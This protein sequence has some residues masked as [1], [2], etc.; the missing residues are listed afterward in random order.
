MICLACWNHSN[1]AQLD[2]VSVQSSHIRDLIN[3]SDL[4]HHL[5]RFLQPLAGPCIVHLFWSVSVSSTTGICLTEIYTV[6]QVKMSSKMFTSGSVSDVSFIYAIFRDLR[7]WLGSMFWSQIQSCQRL[8]W[9][10][11]CFR[12]QHLLLTLDFR[13]F[14]WYCSAISI[15]Q[16]KHINDQS[17][18]RH[19][20]FILKVVNNARRSAGCLLILP[21]QL[22]L[23]TLRS[24]TQPSLE[25]SAVGC[26]LNWNI[27][28][29]IV[30][31][32][33]DINF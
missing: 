22:L 8:P 5:A 15:Q 13:N 33:E 28:F 17:L 4:Q 2:L 21:T 32:K 14:L 20:E 6:R 3:L 23:H 24:R 7:V 27:S 12:Y 11:C 25:N 30:P 31:P 9:A 1:N 26:C 18:Q 19:W 29:V 16:W 10:G